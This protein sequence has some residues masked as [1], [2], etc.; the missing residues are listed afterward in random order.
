MVY[1]V[2]DLRCPGDG[3]PLSP[4]QKKCHFC[5]SPVVITSFNNAYSVDLNKSAMAAHKALTENPNSQP[6]NNF[7]AMCYLKLKLYDKAL[8]AFEKAVEDNFD[9]PETFFYAA[10]SLLKGKKAFLAL[11][12][13]IDKIIEYLNAAVYDRAA[14]N[15]SL[16]FGIYQVRLF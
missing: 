11:R 8:H 15:L 14:R 7:V 5:G 3:A 9:N 13:D 16:F 2:I 4:D 1:Q 10:I 12:P 6:L